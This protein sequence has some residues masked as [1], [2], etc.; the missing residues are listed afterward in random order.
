MTGDGELQEGQIW[1]SLSRPPITSSARSPAIVDHNKLQSDIWV[2]DTSDLGDLEAK[3]AAFGWHVTRCD[4]HDFAALAAALE[5][6]R[7]V[8]DRPK[9]IIADTVK[10]KGVSFMESTMLGAARTLSLSLRGAFTGGLCS[11]SRR[12]DRAH[13]PC[14]RSG[15][16][17]VLCGWIAKSVRHVRNEKSR[18]A[19]SRLYRSADR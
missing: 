16:C 7:N 3:F 8:T 17:R 19:H 14:S 2:R 4:G 11:R 12:T 6:I 18:E 15:G 10:G 5:E 9:V 13:Q 1:E